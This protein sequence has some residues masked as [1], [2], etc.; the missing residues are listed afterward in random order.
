MREQYRHDLIMSTHTHTHTSVDIFY[1]RGTSTSSGGWGFTFLLPSLSL[2]GLVCRGVEPRLPSSTSLR[3]SLR[4]Q[5][6]GKW[7][8]PLL[9]KKEFW[10]KQETW[11]SEL[12]TS[13]THGPPYWEGR[14]L[15]RV[16][17]PLIR[18]RWKWLVWQGNH[19][20]RSCGPLVS[21]KRDLPRVY[22]VLSC[23]KFN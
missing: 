23:H 10:R 9:N 22:L 14:S 19:L 11:V 1:T 2:Y 15:P 3:P 17:R 6:R 5:C 7:T 20:G 8:S 13:V 21:S 16:D 18:T 12:E 4:S